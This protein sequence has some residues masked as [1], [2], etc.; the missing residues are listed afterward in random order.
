MLSNDTA[1][2]GMKIQHSKSLALN[3]L[4]VGVLFSLQHFVGLVANGLHYTPFSVSKSVSSITFDETH[5]YAPPARRFMSLHRFA[6]E[7]DNYER[8]N[9]ASAIPFLPL[10]IL[11]GLGILSHNSLEASFIFADIVFPTF[12]WFLFYKL[13]EGLIRSYEARAALAWA[14]LAIPFGPRNFLW[15][16]YDAALA[17]PDVTRTPQPEISFTIL[18]AALIVLAKALSAKNP[19]R[20]MIAAGILS[21]VVVYSYYFYAIAWAIMLILLLIATLAWRRW[22]LFGRLTIVTSLMGVVAIPFALAAK[23]G[24]A[25]GGQTALLRRMGSM[26]HKPEWIP[27]CL[28][29][30]LF[31]G[32]LLNGKRIF[33]GEL[34]RTRHALLLSLGL[35]GLLGINTQIVTGYNAQHDHFWNRLILPIAFYLGAAMLW[36]WGER[37]GKPSEGTRTLLAKAILLVVLLNVGVRQCY[38]ADHTT[39]SQTTTD[40]RIE[41]MQWVRSYL[42]PETVVGSSDPDLILLIPALTSDYT[43]VPSGLRSLTPTDEILRRYFEL[44]QL[45]GISDEK[46]FQIA[47][48]RAH[49]HA[50]Q[51]LL[52]L[53]INNI[54]PRELI[55][56]YHEFRSNCPTKLT[57]KLDY[58][59][60]G[61]KQATSLR[62]RFPAARA[63]HDNTE[64]ELFDFRSVGHQVVSD[65]LP[66]RFPAGTR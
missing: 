64:Y 34:V 2:R 12:L 49:L 60:V 59:V 41:M 17:A 5:A 52:T 63:V 7:T 27:L 55:E 21:G 6:S 46:M 18:L 8:R 62:Q 15:M 32:L 33:T 47:T 54:T 23:A 35:A 28:A 20:W 42:P 22:A 24:S 45:T 30:L 11:G 51:L 29:F 19:P 26:T 4:L 10:A 25:D 50:S 37:G 43:Y 56:S 13:S 58:L 38:A 1:V 36:W 9:A 16:G 40:S 39:K 57:G 66:S 14:T 65:L 3:L 44:S 48:R 31:I 61:L 53:G